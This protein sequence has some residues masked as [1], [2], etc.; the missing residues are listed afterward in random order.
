MAKVTKKEYIKAVSDA[1]I[2]VVETEL[3]FELEYQDAWYAIVAELILRDGY[4]KTLKFVNSVEKKYKRL[5][6]S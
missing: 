4:E 1:E 5:Y 2:L 3:F 6:R